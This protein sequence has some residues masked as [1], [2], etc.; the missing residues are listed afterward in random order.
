[1]ALCKCNT[2]LKNTYFTDIIIFV[3]PLIHNRALRLFTMCVCQNT[4]TELFQ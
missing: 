4:L 2:S 3:F 1:M